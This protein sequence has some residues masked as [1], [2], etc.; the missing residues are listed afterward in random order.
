MAGNLAGLDT[1]QAAKETV[2]GTSVVATAKL[3]GV[4]ECTIES[5]GG[6]EILSELRGSLAPGFT[7]RKTKAAGKASVKG[8]CTYEDINYYLESL[9]GD[10][11]PSGAGPYIRAGAAPLTAAA[12]NRMMTLYD[13]QSSDVYKLLGS[14]CSKL[15][16]SAKVGEAWKF[17]A[18][19]IGKQKTTGTLAALS[20]RAVNV[21][22]GADT[23][24]YI[25]AWGG[26]IGTTQINTLATAFEL[27][28]DMGNSV[29]FY[30]GSLFGGRYRQ[31]KP[32]PSNTTLKLSLE[33]DATTKAYLDA[34]LTYS[35]VLQHQV[36]LKSTTGANAI[37][38]LDFAGT[39]VGEPTLTRDDEVWSLDIT[40]HGTYNTGLANW[41]K[42]S[43]TCSVAMLV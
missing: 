27:A 23:S 20:D 5:T 33:F 22:D 25:D 2:W 13:G 37:M 40:Y 31:R 3:M 9:L 32:E 4:E 43:N 15:T 41:L 21:I 12:A 26:T 16:L 39:V 28:I 11:T 18:E 42:Y 24:L 7:A 19:F 30:L 36:R 6:A 14:V 38:Q 35:A 34:F 29:R 8:F 17:A 1:I 10:V